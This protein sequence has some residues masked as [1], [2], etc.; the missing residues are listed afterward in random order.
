MEGVFLEEGPIAPAGVDAL[1]AGHG[2]VDALGDLLHVAHVHGHGGLL[3]V[4]DTQLL[5]GPGQ[6][7]GGVGVGEGVE[8]D[9]NVHIGTAGVAD[10]LDAL[11]GDLQ[12][13]LLENAA[14]GPAL[15]FALHVEAQGIHLDAVVAVLL[16][17]D[18]GL[19]VFLGVDKGLGHLAPVKLDLA[20]IGAQL[21]VGLAAQQVVDGGVEGFA[22]DIPQGDVDG[23]HGAVNHRAAAQA[24]E[25][26][27]Q[28]GPNGLVVHGVHADDQLGKVPAHAHRGLLGVAV[29]QTHFAVTAD[30][31]LRVDAHHNR[32]PGAA[33]DRG[34][35]NGDEEHVDAGNFHVN[36]SFYLKSLVCVICVRTTENRRSSR[37]R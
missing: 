10:G 17:L 37:R 12:L 11:I 7:H 24:P 4:V 23:A 18:T 8:L 33:G 27:M 28:A 6:L 22:L 31:V 21:L 26:V 35:T 13:V 1:T 32:I 20:G 29:G 3:V 19:A 15:V 25:G 34:L 2:D 14:T 16:G 9:D 30:A 5:Y 36:R